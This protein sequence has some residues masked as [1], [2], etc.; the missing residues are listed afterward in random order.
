MVADRQTYEQTNKQTDRSSLYMHGY[1]LPE[2]CNHI[3]YVKLV[4]FYV[5]A[6]FVEV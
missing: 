2:R 4:L 1:I 6:V 5:S 3:T